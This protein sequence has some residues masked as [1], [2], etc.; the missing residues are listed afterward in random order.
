MSLHSIKWLVVVMET[1]IVWSWYFTMLQVCRLHDVKW[2]D[3]WWMTNWKGFGRKC[4]SLNELLF[5]PA[6]PRGGWGKPQKTSVRIFGVPAE[7]RKKCLPKNNPGHY[8]EPSST[9]LMFG[10]VPPPPTSSRLASRIPIFP[11]KISGDVNHVVNVTCPPPFH[12]SVPSSG[13]SP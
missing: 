12:S 2:L 6:F 1:Q 9:F 5:I 8:R 13:Y 7:I 11:T 3:D 4:R 10:I